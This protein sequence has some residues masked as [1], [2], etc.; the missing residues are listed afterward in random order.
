MDVFALLKAEDD[1]PRGQAGGRYLSGDSLEAAA[2]AEQRRLEIK[3]ARWTKGRQ[4]EGILHLIKA[5]TL[6]QRLKL[7]EPS[8]VVDDERLWHGSGQCRG[9]K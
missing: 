3:A 5:K 2:A 8:N 7:P 1:N 4:E 6:F 9:R